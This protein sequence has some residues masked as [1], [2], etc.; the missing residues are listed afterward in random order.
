M[1]PPA[2][3]NLSAL[4]IR[5][6]EYLDD[7]TMVDH[8]VG[9]ILRHAPLE[10]HVFFTSRLDE[11]LARLV[12]ERLD[13]LWASLDCEGLSGLDAH[14]I[15]KILDQP[16]H[17]FRRPDDDLQMPSALRFVA[18]DVRQDLGAHTDCIKWVSEVVR[19]DR[20][21]LVSRG[22]RVVLFPKQERV[23]RGERRAVD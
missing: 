8:D 21:Y 23:L 17:A 15:A 13:G 1:W 9:G 7:A 6:V 3:V 11:L 10:S 4:P 5:F 19:H 12:D 14:H 2:G 22:E 18:L 16:I 20:Q